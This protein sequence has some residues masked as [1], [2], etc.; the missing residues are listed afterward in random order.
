M[1]FNIKLDPPRM[2][3]HPHHFKKHNVEISDPYFWFRNKDLPGVIEHLEAENNYVQQQMHP[4]KETQD[5]ILDEL[6]IRTKEEDLSYPIKYG[7]FYYYSKELAGKE[8][9][10]YCRKYKNLNSPEEVLLDLNILAEGKE[11]LDLGELKISPD[12]KILA[13][14]LDYD[15]SEKF[16]IFFKDLVTGELLPQKLTN[17]AP[18]LEWCND[19]QHIYYLELNEKHVANKVYFYKIGEPVLSAQMIYTEKDPDYHLDLSKSKSGNFIFLQS[20]THANS[21]TQYISAQSLEKEFSLVS[22]RRKGVIYNV[23]DSGHNSF[24][25]YTN[26]QATNFKIME[27]AVGETDH[28]QWQELISHNENIYISDIDVFNDHILLSERHQGL[29]RLRDFIYSTKQFVNISLPEENCYISSYVNYDFNGPYFYFSY[30]SLISPPSVLT[31]NFSSSEVTTCKVKEV[32]TYIKSKYVTKRILAKSHDGKEIPISLVYNKELQ[33]NG[34]HPCYLYAYGSYGINISPYFRQYIFSLIDRGF[35]FAIAHV[36]GGAMMG[37]HWYEDGK[38]LNKKN[39]FSDFISCA[40]HL[41]ADNYTYKKG[42][43]I[44]GASAGGLLVGTTVN[45]RPDL[46][47]AVTANVPFVDNLNTM[48]D[49]SLPLTT[50][51]YDEWG[52]PNEKEYFDYIRSYASYE[53]VKKQEYPHMYVTAGLNDPRVTY[54]EP[55]KWVAK[56][57]EFKTDNNVI[58]LKTNMEAGHRG[59][60]GRFEHLK[61]FAEEYTFVLAAFDL[62]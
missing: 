62:I 21:E 15:G 6:K 47:K 35:I 40:E 51:E 44:S 58:L 2:K 4:Y 48:L 20:F 14:C 49:D 52:N 8:Y 17:C 22:A 19:N 27:A 41:I 5:K 57:R 18:S 1:A 39:T 60:T 3:Q 59:H 24:I 50:I 13:Y 9:S 11:Y 25:I 53:N 45:L 54:W 34:S 43:V 30:S 32:P 61:D 7:D 46:F 42:I 12:H 26:D 23:E 29:P 56:L 31:Y 55:A 16:S 38:L 33:K 37:R 28:N 36:R 10:I